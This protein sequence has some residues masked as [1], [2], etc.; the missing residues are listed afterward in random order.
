FLNIIIDIVL[1]V[2]G[3]VI[4]FTSAY[5]IFN[6]F[7]MT[8]A[9]RR[10]DIGRL[11]ALGMTPQQATRSIVTESLFIG[12]LGSLVGLVL[13]AFLTVPVELAINST[14]GK[15]F[16]WVPLSLPAAIV[17]VFMGLAVT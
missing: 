6:T 13:G 17:A 4:L 9:E 11:V 8:L 15:P 2:G 5:L 7:A 10:T 1:I 14:M 3:C 16:A 12:A